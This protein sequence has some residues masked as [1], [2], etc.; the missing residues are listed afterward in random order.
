MQAGPKTKGTRLSDQLH[1]VIYVCR[2]LNREATSIKSSTMP[3]QNRYKAD[4]GHTTYW[5]LNQC[6]YRRIWRRAAQVKQP[7]R[8]PDPGRFYRIGIGL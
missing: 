7:R 4:I 5:Y 6:L 1:E 3:I 2:N 8:S